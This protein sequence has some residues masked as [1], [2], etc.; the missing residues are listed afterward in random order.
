DDRW[1]E[2]NSNQPR[3]TY[4][5]KSYYDNRP[6]VLRNL[7][8]AVISCFFYLLLIRFFLRRATHFAIVN[9]GASGYLEL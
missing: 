4:V 1:I 6:F 2:L 5:R 8:A 3:L 7:I 9:H